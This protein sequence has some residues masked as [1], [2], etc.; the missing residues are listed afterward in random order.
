MNCPFK[1]KA[2]AI[3]HGSLLVSYDKSY[4]EPANPSNMCRRAY[5]SW[6]LTRFA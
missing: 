1:T 6:N 4:R 2:A 5:C 3:V